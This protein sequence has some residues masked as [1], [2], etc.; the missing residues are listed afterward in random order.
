MIHI[1]A[2]SFR[3]IL[4]GVGCYFM[5][6]NRG[7][8]SAYR[9]CA[10]FMWQIICHEGDRSKHLQSGAMIIVILTYKEAEPTGGAGA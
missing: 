5:F 2:H 4:M 9:N 8:T 3:I 7:Q 6:L 10:V 1:H